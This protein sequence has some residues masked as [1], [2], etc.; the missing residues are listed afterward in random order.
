VQSRRAEPPE[1][2]AAKVLAR[3]V[4]HAASALHDVA[5]KRSSRNFPLGARTPHCGQVE[6]AGRRNKQQ[7]YNPSNLRDVGPRLKFSWEVIV[8]I[9]TVLNRSLEP[10]SS[11]FEPNPR[12]RES[13]NTEDNQR[14][15]DRVQCFWC[16]CT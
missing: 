12:D 6:D 2:H 1:A 8:P 5:F 4:R 14:R 9:R 16:A 7:P 10:G 13:S 15:D 11:P 3:L